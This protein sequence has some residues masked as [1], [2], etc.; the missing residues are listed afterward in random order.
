MW[1][2]GGRFAQDP[3]FDARPNQKKLLQQMQCRLTFAKLLKE[4]ASEA[5]LNLNLRRI[6]HPLAEK[7][8]YTSI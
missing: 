7:K 5:S 3:G 2:H 1:Q 4:I 8:L 6:I